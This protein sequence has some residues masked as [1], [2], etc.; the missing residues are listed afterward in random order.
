MKGVKLVKEVRKRWRWQT[1][2]AV[3]VAWHLVRDRWW[4]IGAEKYR[5]SAAELVVIAPETLTIVPTG[6][7]PSFVDGCH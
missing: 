6:V 5:E 3:A 1:R 7:V 2:M 4:M